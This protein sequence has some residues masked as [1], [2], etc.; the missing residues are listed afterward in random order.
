MN[1]ERWLNLVVSLEKVD[2][3]PFCV[4]RELPAYI[5]IDMN[6]SGL[7]ANGELSVVKVDVVGRRFGGC[8]AVEISNRLDRRPRSIVY[9]G[10]FSVSRG[11]SGS[12]PSPPPTSP[13]ASPQFVNASPTRT[14]LVPNLTRCYPN[15]RT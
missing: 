9:S 8:L 4:L 3:V 13:T 6:R 11:I 14:R 1:R 2:F 5:R 15:H 12:Q 7:N 10:P